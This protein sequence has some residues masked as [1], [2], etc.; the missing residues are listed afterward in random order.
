MKTFEHNLNR[1]I[2][3]RFIDNNRNTPMGLSL[4]P[5]HHLRARSNLHELSI[6]TVRTVKESIEHI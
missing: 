6:V 5:I 1:P 4:Q 3:F 2:E